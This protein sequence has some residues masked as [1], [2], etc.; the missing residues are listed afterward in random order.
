MNQA[1]LRTGRDPERVV[2]PVPRLA[3]GGYCD[4]LEHDCSNWLGNDQLL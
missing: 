1:A 4:W 3:G 2:Y